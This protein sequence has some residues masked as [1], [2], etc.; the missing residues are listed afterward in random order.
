[1]RDAKADEDAGPPVVA[2][3]LPTQLKWLEVNYGGA[4]FLIGSCGACEP[5]SREPA[6]PA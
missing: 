3:P 6:L 1:M 2:Q 5:L 4:T